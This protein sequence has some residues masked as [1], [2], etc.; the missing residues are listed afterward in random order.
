MLRKLYCI[1][2]TVREDD[3]IVGFSP[4]FEESDCILVVNLFII[5][6]IVYFWPLLPFYCIKLEKLTKSNILDALEH[7][8]AF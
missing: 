3:L 1:F 8:L 7:F 2:Y 4:L 5:L 6:T